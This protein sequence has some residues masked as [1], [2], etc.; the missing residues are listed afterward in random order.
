MKI[1]LE[2][3]TGEYIMDLDMKDLDVNRLIKFALLRMPQEK[4]MSYG[5]PLT[6]SNI[7]ELLEFA[8]C[9]LLQDEIDKST[10]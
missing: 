6:E 10:K 7:T 4:A 8:V 2:S 1:R 5:L 3:T 9:T